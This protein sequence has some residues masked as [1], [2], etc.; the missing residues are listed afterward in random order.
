MTEEEYKEKRREVPNSAFG[1][2]R[3]ENEAFY[4]KL[5]DEYR[6]KR[7][8]MVDAASLLSSIS[9]TSS[10]NFVVHGLAN[11]GPRMLDVFENGLER[12]R[13]EFLA[14]VD[15][16]E[17]RYREEDMERGEKYKYGTDENGIITVTENRD[18]QPSKLDLSSMPR[19]SSLLPD[20]VALSGEAL[21]YIGVLAFYA[22]VFFAVAYVAF[23]RYDAR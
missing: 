8:E 17:E 20:A 23:L 12:Y 18:Y 14:Y 5:S 1:R 22:I 11:T 19:F 6:R 15:D 13:T 4:G 21:P 2:V 3:K 16:M 9:P 7:L 10:M